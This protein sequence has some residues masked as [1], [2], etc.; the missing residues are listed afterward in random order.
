[1]NDEVA[2]LLLEFR[3]RYINGEHGASKCNLSGEEDMHE[4]LA[5]RHF[6]LCQ[7]VVASYYNYYFELARILATL[8]LPVKVSCPTKHLPSRSNLPKISVAKCGLELNTLHLFTINLA[9]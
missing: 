1:M 8:F 6:N 3:R 4:L 7:G 5:S 9:P 2:S